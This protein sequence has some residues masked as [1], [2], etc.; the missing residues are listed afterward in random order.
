MDP[1]DGVSLVRTLL[2]V[3][4]GFIM[5]LKV[6]FDWYNLRSVSNKV[7]HSNGKI[8]LT[9]NSSSAP[10][11]SLSKKSESPTNTKLSS[12]NEMH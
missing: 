7:E 12:S 8:L 9:G 4:C 6:C 10:C 11:R 1:R 3:Q 5:H 2:T